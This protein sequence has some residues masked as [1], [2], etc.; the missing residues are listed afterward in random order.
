M[1]TERDRAAEWVAAELDRRLSESMWVVARSW[2]DLVSAH[3]GLDSP[4]SVCAQPWFQDMW[5]ELAQMPKPD[6]V[7]VDDISRTFPY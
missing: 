7:S 1:T 5:E 4:C 3:H 6:G 2:A